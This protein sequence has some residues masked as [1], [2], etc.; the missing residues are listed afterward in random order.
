MPL[1]NRCAPILLTQRVFRYTGSPLAALERHY[2]VAEI[3]TL[4]NISKDTVRAL[5]RDD[6]SVLKLNSPEHRHK[7]GYCIL[8]VPESTL[9]RV[10]ERL[11]AGMA[12]G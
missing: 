2:S 6:P 3:A 4:W 8:R 7:R 1:R 5:F 10:H 11:R 9:Q 12:R